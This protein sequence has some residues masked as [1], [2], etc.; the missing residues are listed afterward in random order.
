MPHDSKDF[1]TA[2]MFDNQDKKTIYD[3]QCGTKIY[4]NLERKLGL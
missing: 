3:F 2:A 1:T 4:M